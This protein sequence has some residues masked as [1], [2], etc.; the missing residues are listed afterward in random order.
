MGGVADGG[1]LFE[2]LEAARED[3]GLRAVVI[4]ARGAEAGFSAGAGTL[5]AIARFALPTVFL[6][7]GQRVT[8]NLLELAAACDIRVCDRETEW[9]LE[10]REGVRLRTLLGEDGL[11]LRLL[12]QGEVFDGP[13]AAA[14]GLSAVAD[15]AAAEA[16]RLAGVIASRGP[17]A[18]QLGKEAVWRGL[19]MPLEQG[20]RFELDLTLLLQTTKDRAEGVQAFLEKR[21]PSFTGE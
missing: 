1:T 3:E 6:A 11:G 10:G 13:S 17:L 14:V 19:E 16:E 21:T 15:D 4:D 12:R 2:R 20:L 8:G 5:G 9:V 18:T 7:A